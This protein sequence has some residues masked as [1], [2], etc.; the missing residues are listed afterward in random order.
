MKRFSKFS[1]FAALWSLVILAGAIDL[2]AQTKR[3][4]VIRKKTVVRKVVR[5]A[6]KLYT[7]TAGQAIRARMNGT[8]SSKTARIGNTFMATVT[9]PVYSSTGVVVVPTGATVVGRVDSVTPARKGGN[10]G[11]INV[12]FTTLRWRVSG[13]LNRSPGAPRGRNP[14]GWGWSGWRRSIR[15][16]FRLDP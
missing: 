15:S 2:D 13:C 10:P 7:V 14:F 3:R 5:P 16:R 4:P 11:Q 12:S 1:I 9:E 6:V 8:I